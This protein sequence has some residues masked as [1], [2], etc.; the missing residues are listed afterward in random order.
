[1]EHRT[2]YLQL[3]LSYV[4]HYLTRA[5]ESEN[6]HFWVGWEIQSSVEDAIEYK[7]IRLNQTRIQR[8]LQTCIVE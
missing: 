7:G 1:M 3:N 4:I 5:D 6:Q 8:V 2:P